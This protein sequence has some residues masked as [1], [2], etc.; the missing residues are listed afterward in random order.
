MIPKRIHYVWIGHGEMSDTIKRCIHSWEE[1]LPN[2]EIMRWDESNYDI[3]NAPRFVQE[4]YNAK[5]WAFVSDYIRLWALY[6]YGG[7]YLDTDVEVFKSLDIF[8]NHPLFIGTQS[9]WVDINKREKELKVNLS[10]GVIGAEKEHPYIKDCL[11]YFDNVSI[12]TNNHEV[13]TTVTNYKMAEILSRYGY[14]NKDARQHLDCG[15][16]VFTTNEFGDRLSPTPHNNCYTYHWGEMSWFAPKKRGAF[17]FLCWHLNL[18]P[19]YHKIEHLIKQIRT[20][21]NK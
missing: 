1:K 5:K 16:E 18:M 3:R 6:N 14:K 11:S 20:L 12:A 10:I 4:T 21:I 7:I 15:I 17:H 2:Y 9:Y 19:F 8:L 13:D